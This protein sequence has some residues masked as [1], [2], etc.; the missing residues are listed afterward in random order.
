[1]AGLA[2]LTSVFVVAGAAATARASWQSP[3]ALLPQGERS[4]EVDARVDAGGTRFVVWR[5]RGSARTGES[6][7]MAQ[8]RAAGG[9]W[10]PAVRISGRGVYPGEV[11][12]VSNARGDEA[13]AW[14]QSPLGKN[15]WTVFA[16]RRA[17]GRAWSAPVRL[18]SPGIEGRLPIIAI[19]SAGGLVV[20]WS[21][22]TQSSPASE[23][24]E[25]AV[26]SVVGGWQ[27]PERVGVPGRATG[28]RGAAIGALEDPTILLSSSRP[29]IHHAQTVE[30][31]TRAREG[32]WQEPVRLSSTLVDAERPEL[33][34]GSA[35][36]MTVSWEAPGVAQRS[37]QIQ[38]ASFTPTEG[39]QPPVTLA[40][41]GVFSGRYLQ[42]YDRAAEPTVTVGTQG[43]ASVIWRRFPDATHVII[44]AATR[45][46]GGVWQAP[47]RPAG[48]AFAIPNPYTYQGPD[49]QIAID[50]L[51]NAMASWSRWDGST[52][53]VEAAARTAG[54]L[55]QPP[56]T[57]SPLRSQAEQSYELTQSSIIAFPDGGFLV[58]WS[59]EGAVNPLFPPPNL[60]NEAA[61]DI[62]SP[63]APNLPPPL[64]APSLAVGPVVIGGIAPTPWTTLRDLRTSHSIPVSCTLAGPGVCAIHVK[65]GIPSRSGRSDETN[66]ATVSVV[67][68][69]RTQTKRVDV[70]IPRRLWRALKTAHSLRLTVSA[71]D[72]AHQRTTRSVTIHLNPPPED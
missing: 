59:T 62:L 71:I 28:P 64:P 66:L 19:G 33:A 57:L 56:V 8:E 24:T 9:A 30:V 58:S 5:D 54:G 63:D 3:T 21:R 12:L 22:S 46:S 38:A 70:P 34:V 41:F 42:S 44:E 36:E 7:L 16:A 72:S 50:G 43:D 52:E 55:W 29:G 37:V 48:P 60:T 20:A 1:M 23:V 11:K 26:G 4:D 45:T 68:A 31:T 61:L 39:W 10:Q 27:T 6:F 69:G 67:V 65:L 40:N 25:A 47:G 14:E 49:E 18:S 13:V 53:V 15:Q 51:G 17:A 32:D 2:I 35:G